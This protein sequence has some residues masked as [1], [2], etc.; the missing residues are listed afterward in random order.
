MKN[1]IPPAWILWFVSPILGE[2]FSGS[3]PLDEYINPFSILMLGMLYGSGAVLIRELLVHWKKGWLSLLLLGLAYGI[4]EEGLMVRSFFDPNWMDLDVLG[5]YG[6]VFGVNWVWTEHLMIFHA[7]I[8]IAASITLVEMLYPARRAESWIGRRGLT[9]N[10]LAFAATLPLGALL[11]P[12]DT[13]DGWLGACWL[14]IAALTL[15]A[16]RVSGKA[17]EPGVVKVPAPA[18]F[19]FVGFLGY[20]GQFLILYSTAEKNSPPFV[21]TMLLVALYDLFI[22]W[23]LLRWSGGTR[24]WDDRHRLALICGAL[25][26][27]LILGPLTM[28]GQYP[29]MYYSNPVFLLC[30]WFIYRKVKK[31]VLSESSVEAD[32]I[33]RPT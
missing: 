13:P 31:R 32:T 5:T 2:L 3:T 15:A 17:K 25:S 6:R 21:I 18:L 26:F 9:W 12:Y 7:L 4:Y 11:N 8:S 28:N 27:F 23:L 1:S 10:I 22:L 14:A 29:V 33:S 30:L 20:L 16:W 19:W 24:A